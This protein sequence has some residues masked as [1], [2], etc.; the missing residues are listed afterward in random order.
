MRWWTLRSPLHI[1]PC[2]LSLRLNAQTTNEMMPAQTTPRSH[3][4]QPRGTPCCSND[5]VGIIALIDET[6]AVE[7][8]PPVLL[9]LKLAVDLDALA[10]GKALV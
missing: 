2:A 10:V 9:L 6:R 8:V 4:T 1:V 7:L 5:I 3:S